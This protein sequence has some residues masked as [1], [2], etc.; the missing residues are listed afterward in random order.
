MS[1]DP[2]RGAAYRIETGRLVLRCWTPAD[3]R[4]VDDAMR[5]GL[6]ELARWVPR[7][8]REPLPPAERLLMLRQWRGRFDLGLD[9]SYGV[10]DA[11]ETIVYG[12]VGLH[13]RVGPGSIELGYWIR[14]GAVRQGIASAA[15]GALTMV[16]LAAGGI[17]RVEI[18]CNPHNLA[19]AA[20]ARKLGFRHDGTIRGRLIEADG[21]RH[22]AMIWTMLAGELPGSPLSAIELTAYDALG[23]PMFRHPVGAAR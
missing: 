22:D 11:G 20:V 12:G 18:H 15:A 13:P 14:A 3:A 7:F 17:E 6:H 1:D 19:S 21:N 16:A 8:A 9:Y 5:D 4:L 2:Q 10:F 23:E